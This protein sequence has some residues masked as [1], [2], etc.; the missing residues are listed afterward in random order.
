MKN[1]RFLVLVAS[2][3]ALA[4]SIASCDKKEP[5]APVNPPT[6]EKPTPDKP[7]P[8][9]AKVITLEKFNKYVEILPADHQGAYMTIISDTKEYLKVYFSQK[10]G[11]KIYTKLIPVAYQI[12]PKTYKIKLSMLEK[13]VYEAVADKLILEQNEYRYQEPYK[14]AKET[15]QPEKQ[16]VSIN[17]SLDQIIYKG[18]HPADERKTHT[19]VLEYF[20]E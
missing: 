8:E 15:F 9:K 11:R 16:S 2:L 20:E 10:V 7:T 13:S 1:F 3:C 5:K 12:D 18:Y 14:S 19:S 17:K 6:P 4:L